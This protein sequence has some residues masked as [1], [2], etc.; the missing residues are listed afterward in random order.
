MKIAFVGDVMLGRL[1]NDKLT[2]ALPTFP[3]GD[4]LPDL[5]QADIRIGNLECVIADDGTPWPGSTMTS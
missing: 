5:R 2:G 1:V 4:T 3:W